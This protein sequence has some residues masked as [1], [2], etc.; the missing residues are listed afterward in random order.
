MGKCYYFYAYNVV[1]VKIT[2][3]AWIIQYLIWNVYY[4][5]YFIVFYIL[6]VGCR[7]NS[8]CP[9]KQA[10]QNKKC[11][12]PCGFGQCGATQD[13]EVA[14]HLAR[15]IDGRKLVMFNITETS[16]MLIANYPYKIYPVLCFDPYIWLLWSKKQMKG[17][18]K[19]EESLSLCGGK[20]L[21]CPN[22]QLQFQILAVY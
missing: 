20:T 10:C 11:V 7:S 19:L 9:S 8:E 15:C 1:W 13:C 4:W 16:F 22:R 14:N 17:C 21:G 6:G 3:F 2:Y 5:V 18:Q 12:N